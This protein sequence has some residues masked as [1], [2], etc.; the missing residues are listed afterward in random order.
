MSRNSLPRPRQRLWQC[1]NTHFFQRSIVLE[2]AVYFLPYPTYHKFDCCTEHAERSRCGGA[3]AR[4][5]PL[6]TSIVLARRV[7]VSQTV[8]LTQAIVSTLRCHQGGP[9][10][11]KA[12]IWIREHF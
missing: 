9:L 8:I 12:K 2:S 3:A 5:I 1:F 10:A 7:F 6:R 4:V 11:H